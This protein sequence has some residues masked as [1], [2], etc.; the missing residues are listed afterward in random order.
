MGGVTLL[1]ACGTDDDV[2]DVVDVPVVC[3]VVPLF[4]LAL[5]KGRTEKMCKVKSNNDRVIKG[6]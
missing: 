1:G 3:S 5:L 2:D 6:I 4:S